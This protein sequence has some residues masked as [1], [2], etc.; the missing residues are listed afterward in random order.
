MQNIKVQIPNAI[1]SA[2]ILESGT[3]GIEN[4]ML[5]FHAFSDKM[6]ACVLERIAAG[7]KLIISITNEAPRV[8][9]WM[10]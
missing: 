5:T 7:D 6:K 9:E 2:S 3:K 10:E 1:S 8:G 4:K